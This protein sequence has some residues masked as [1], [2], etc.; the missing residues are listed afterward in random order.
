MVDTLTESRTEYLDHVNEKMEQFVEK[1]E[2]VVSEVPYKNNKLLR[3]GEGGDDDDDAEST[4]S[5][6]TELFHRDFGTQTSSPVLRP[7]DLNSASGNQS[8][9]VIDAQVRRLA[10]VRASLREMNDMHI[11]RAEDSTNL[12]A[13][14]R[15]V[16]DE[17]DKLGA[18]PLADFTSIHSGLGYGRSAEPDDEVKKTKDAIRSVKG[19]FLSTRRF[20]ASA[21]R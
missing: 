2:G 16:R 14:L 19:M 9:K 1:L 17:I 13:I 7:D 4:F 6:P 18:P 8:G 12:N 5:D 3:S 20:P 21:A 15:E 11:R 10:A